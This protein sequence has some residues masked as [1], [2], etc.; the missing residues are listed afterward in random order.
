VQLSV[1][2]SGKAL[3][4]ILENEYLKEHFLFLTVFSESVVCYE[5]SGIL[6]GKLVELVKNMKRD[7]VFTLAIGDG[8]NDV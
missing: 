4:L 7:S 6:K 3:E 8:L 1:I 5:T 2:A